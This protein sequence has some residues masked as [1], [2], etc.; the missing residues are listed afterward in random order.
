MK[1]NQ[2][3]EALT[4]YTEAL[5]LDPTNPILYCNR[6]LK[7]FFFRILF[8]YGQHFFRFQSF[9]LFSDQFS[10][11]NGL[12]INGTVLTFSRSIRSIDRLID[13]LICRSIVCFVDWLID[14]LIFHWLLCPAVK[15]IWLLLFFRAAAY[16]K[17]NQH[18][19]AAKDCEIALAFDSNYAKAYGRY[20][21]VLCFFSILHPKKLIQFPSLFF[22]PKMKIGVA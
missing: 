3:D 21:S 10:C 7:S 2:I 18:D 13:W 20:G 15:Y 19:L 22:L 12:W 17:L 5:T 8:G 1:S 11:L 4:A 6:Y 16:S 14:W 9:N